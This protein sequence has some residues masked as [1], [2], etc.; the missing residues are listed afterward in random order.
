MKYRNDWH[1][2]STE[3]TAKRLG[4]D[5]YAGLSEREVRRRRTKYGKNRI[6]RIARTD[7]GDAVL[8]ALGDFSTVLLIIA[9]VLAFLF[10]ESAEAVAM[11]VILALGAALRIVTYIK[12]KRV[13]EENASESIPT[14]AVLRDGKITLINSVELV[15]GD[16]VLLYPG[17]VVPCDGRVLTDAEAVVSEAGVTENRERVRKFNVTIKARPGSAAIPCESRP[18]ILF[19]GSAILHGE[20]RMIAT[21]TGKRAL[22]SMK[23]GGVEIPAG[24]DLPL[25]E[26]LN[27]WRR[28]SELIML[29]L[30]L[31]VSAL[32]MFAGNGMTLEQIFFRAVSLAA[33]SMSEY[34]TAIGYIIIAIAARRSDNVGERGAIIR[35]CSELETVAGVDGVVLSD[36][37]LLKSGN[38]AFNS[39]FIHGEIHA[40]EELS[41]YAESVGELLFL[42]META[43]ASVGNHMLSA[44]A[45]ESVSNVRER[46]VR[47][48]AELFHKK[49]GKDIPKTAFVVD[50]MSASAALSGG[51]DTAIFQSMEQGNP[52]L[53]AAVGDIQTLLSCCSRYRTE[54]GELPLT[55]AV[56]KKIFTETARLEFIGARIVAVA[57]RP[58]PFLTLSK[59][60]SLH[61][62]M[63]F[64]GF[65]S[66]SESPARGAVEA[67]RRVRAANFRVILFSDNPEHDLYYGHELGL[68]DKKTQTLPASDFSPAN[69]ADKSLIVSFPPHSR[70]N[71]ELR[72][73]LVGAAG[74]STVAFIT[75]EPSDARALAA[76]GC[77]IAVGRSSRRAVAQA[78]K[79][80]AQVVAYPDAGENHGGFAEG[81][82]ALQEARRAMINLSNVAD[83]LVSSQFSRLFVVL[84]GVL[85]GT[86][87]PDACAILV[88]GLLLDFAAVLAMAFE[89]APENALGLSCSPLPEYVAHLKY[90]A[91]V[92]ILSSLLCAFLS[93]L[94]NLVLSAAH[95]H[96]LSAAEAVSLLTAALFLSQ[97]ATAVQFMKREPLLRR[98]TLFNFACVCC[99][100][101]SVLLAALTLL[102]P[103]VA[104]LLGGATVPLYV[105]PAVLLPPLVLFSV[106]EIRKI[107]MEKRTR[108]GKNGAPARKG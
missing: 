21:A 20:T 6:W 98:R 16:V 85:F 100:A 87:M 15:P 4:V 102:N 30:V 101:I 96:R 74:G 65:L 104:S 94:T 72:A 32:S 8:H 24:D 76:A 83:Y 103:N 81:I 29:A 95:L 2:I 17:D 57:A 35:D 49:T 63:C 91:A 47:L 12:A 79:N 69:R 19:A 50:R 41:Q 53:A 60:A 71:S 5:P 56:R 18:N 44:G 93:P 39:F 9:A 70:S 13:L 25:I 73:K 84:I 80:Q 59:V 45:A 37:S 89:K 54:N 28:T 55:D 10:E 77:G 1:T 58:S 51:M 34:L 105:A 23:Q 82:A 11:C 78:L 68:F 62:D 99:C 108:R 36:I 90:T 52:P 7:A 46:A 107:R 31:V 22:I 64:L 38:A 42:A 3:E 40:K 75:R 48:A 92:G 86:V 14:A 67:V 66:L 27:G 97:T 26:R 33:A 88:G 43:G 106:I 61:R